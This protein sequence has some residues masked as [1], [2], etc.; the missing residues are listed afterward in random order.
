MFGSYQLMRHYT[1]LQ[2]DLICSICPSKFQ[3]QQYLSWLQALNLIL[4][5]APE[6]A[7]MRSL[8]KQSLVN[9]A[10]RDLFV[11]L[12]SSWCHSPIATVSLCLLAQV[13][14][15]L[16]W[17]RKCKVSHLAISWILQSQGTLCSWMQICEWTCGIGTNQSDCAKRDCFN[18]IGLPACKFSHPGTWGIWYQR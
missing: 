2:E 11:S 6:L 8:L 16:F 3:Q 4:L 9:P 15:C 12:Y 7:D 13:N 18:D 14:L 10:G 1:S 17:N 5:T